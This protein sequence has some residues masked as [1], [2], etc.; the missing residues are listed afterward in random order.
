MKV[1]SRLLLITT[2]ISFSACTM[3]ENPKVQAGAIGGVAGAGIGAGT[4]A[5]VG[6]AIAN[7]DV[8]AS[9]LLGAGLGLP[10]GVVA[11][12]AYINYVQDKELR[13]NNN[14]IL[15]NQEYLAA[16][17]AELEES[18]QNVEAELIDTRIDETRRDYMFTGPTLGGY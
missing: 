18:R 4:G 8:T 14:V 16:R 13:D 3:F 17:Q 2:I 7:G 12:V 5:L 1:F 6:S 9:A 11:G 10:A 15:E